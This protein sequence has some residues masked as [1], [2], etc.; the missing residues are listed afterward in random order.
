MH[1]PGIKMGNVKIT[2]AELSP[3]VIRFGVRRK[4]RILSLSSV[5]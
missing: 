4:S 5:L 2:D 3:E 1:V